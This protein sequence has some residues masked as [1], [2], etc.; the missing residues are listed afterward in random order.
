MKML[1][2]TSTI[3]KTRTM[4]EAFESGA[5]RDTQQGKP[6]F[7]LISPGFTLAVAQ[8]LGDKAEHYGERNWEKGIPTDR[9]FGSLERHMQ[10]LK[11]GEWIDPES[12]HPH[13]AHIAA[14]TMF[15]H[16]FHG[17]EFDTLSELRGPGLSNLNRALPN[18]M[19]REYSE[20]VYRSDPE[21]SRDFTYTDTDGDLW[22][23]ST[24]QCKWECSATWLPGF[25]W[26]QIQASIGTEIDSFPWQRTYPE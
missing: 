23:Y 12:G 13:T 5:I 21:P 22:R 24:S 10:A 1:A 20:K 15:I 3:R 17:T 6:R 9:S 11:R 19:V 7:D 25:T 8:M 4:T 26:E 18:R 2:G 14:N 16:E